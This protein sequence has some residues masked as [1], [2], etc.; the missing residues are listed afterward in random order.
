MALGLLLASLLLF[1]Y[2][3]WIILALVLLVISIYASLSDA[4]WW[5]LLI[6]GLVGY[7]VGTLN[8][9]VRLGGYSGATR[10]WFWPTS[11]SLR[12]DTLV[13]Y[14]SACVCVLIYALLYRRT[15]LMPSSYDPW[16][17]ADI[18]RVCALVLSGVTLAFAAWIRK[19]WLIQAR[20]VAPYEHMMIF[21]ELA[22]VTF[23][24]LMIWPTAHSGRL[25]V[26]VTALSCVILSI[27]ARRAAYVVQQ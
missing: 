25:A 22:L 10:R 27:V 21:L 1:A 11:Q 26:L 18:G 23:L 8:R 19:A 13:D 14:I 24:D 3:E 4:S 16:H 20:P 17:S 7:A 9:Y 2:V 12:N 15:L 6:Q 5:G